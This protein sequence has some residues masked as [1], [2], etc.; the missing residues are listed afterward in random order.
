MRQS[1]KSKQIKRLEKHFNDLL[2]NLWRLECKL[3]KARKIEVR[4]FFRI[5]ECAQSILDD[6]G[7]RFK[8]IIRKD[9]QKVIFHT[10]QR[11][12]KFNL[13]FERV[14]RITHLKIHDST[15]PWMFKQ[16]LEILDKLNAIITNLSF[17]F[18]NYP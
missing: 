18:Q 4:L 11:I 8:I 10:T 12:Q 3:P 15:N 2:L 1:R 9:S 7:L 16:I 14:R 6:C 17:I 5:F 13:I